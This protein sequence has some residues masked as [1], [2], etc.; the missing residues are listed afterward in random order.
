MSFKTSTGHYDCAVIKTKISVP[1]NP[2]IKND[3]VINGDVTSQNSVN[4]KKEKEYKNLICLTRENCFKEIC[5]FSSGFQVYKISAKIRFSTNCRTNLS[6][7]LRL[8]ILRGV[9]GKIPGKSNHRGSLRQSVICLTD[10]FFLH[11]I[12]QY[13]HTANNFS[14]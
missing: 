5:Y 3:P 4:A 13:I 8:H 1:G 9:F 6:N 7:R 11:L 10:L 14:E 2:V 12:P